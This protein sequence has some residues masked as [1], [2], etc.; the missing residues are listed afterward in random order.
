MPHFKNS[1]IKHAIKNFINVILL[2]Y[3]TSLTLYTNVE[4]IVFRVC[5]RVSSYIVLV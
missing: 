2:N 1:N 4:Y 5:V 3:P